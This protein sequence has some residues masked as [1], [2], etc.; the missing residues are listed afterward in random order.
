MPVSVFPVSAIVISKTF[1][2]EAKTSCVSI[3]FP[4]K[5]YQ[6]LQG[7]YFHNLAQVF[8]G[9]SNAESKTNGVARKGFHT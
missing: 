7:R 2:D 6:H 9:V 8:L 3:S 4:R 1:D 5:Y